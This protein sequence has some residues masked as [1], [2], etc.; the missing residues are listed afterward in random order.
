MCQFLANYSFRRRFDSFIASESNS[1][2]WILMY[3]DHILM[4]FSYIKCVPFAPSFIASSFL[5]HS[6]DD[7]I[8]TQA[9]HSFTEWNEKSLFLHSSKLTLIRL[10]FFIFFVSFLVALVLM[11]ILC[12]YELWIMC[13]WSDRDNEMYEKHIHPYTHAY[14]NILRRIFSVTCLHLSE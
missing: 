10:M 9:V 14:N 8:Q 4:T 1:W 2:H 5:L 13:I 12:A 11:M 7:A 3:K 6:S